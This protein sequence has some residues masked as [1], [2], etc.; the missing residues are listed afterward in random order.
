VLGEDLVIQLQLPRNKAVGRQFHKI[1]PKERDDVVYKI[2]PIAPQKE[3][4]G[5]VVA[6]PQMESGFRL[7]SCCKP[8]KQGKGVPQLSFYHREFCKI[9]YKISPRKVKMKIAVE[10]EAA[11]G[12]VFLV[13]GVQSEVAKSAVVI[14]LV[15]DGHG[16]AALIAP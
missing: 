9:V 7:K 12:I 10:K 14:A 1:V 5:L 2:V 3:V 13:V 6:V 16:E 8:R 11:G 15:E 4:Q